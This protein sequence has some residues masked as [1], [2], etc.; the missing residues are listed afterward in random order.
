MLGQRLDATQ[1]KINEI[2]DRMQ[3]LPGKK[4]KVLAKIMRKITIRWANL[5]HNEL[6]QALDRIAELEQEVEELKNERN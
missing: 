6:A 3:G 5:Y 2:A 4:L 1:G